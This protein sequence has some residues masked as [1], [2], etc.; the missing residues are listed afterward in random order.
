MIET[1]KNVSYLL[2]GVGAVLLILFGLLW[3]DG[4]IV[5]AILLLAGFFI[6]ALFKGE[7]QEPE[8]RR[9]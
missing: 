4:L 8:Y 6:R 1:I 9:F 7:S 5:P 3:Q 2:I